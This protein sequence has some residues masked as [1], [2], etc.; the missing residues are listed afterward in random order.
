M[1][2]VRWYLKGVRLALRLFPS[3]VATMGLTYAAGELL[4]FVA[5]AKLR[6]FKLTVAV[7]ILI[8]AVL[9]MVGVILWRTRP[10]GELSYSERLA[11]TQLLIGGLA[12]FLAGLGGLAAFYQLQLATIAPHFYL[13]LRD[14]E[15]Q[16]RPLI[17][18]DRRRPF[19]G[20]MWLVNFAPVAGTQVKIRVLPTEEAGKAFRITLEGRKKGLDG[21][22]D[23]DCVDAGRQEWYSVPDDVV[24]HGDRSQ[25]VAKIWVERLAAPLPRGQHSFIQVDVYH[26]RGKQTFWLRVVESAG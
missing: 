9:A 4:E 11:W 25:L 20:L 12:L 24:I 7:A 16:L 2:R 6:L 1:N 8:V 13:F 15:T 19:S 5:P 17:S 21:A 23:F 22:L 10:S 18:V 14:H 26:G 3:R